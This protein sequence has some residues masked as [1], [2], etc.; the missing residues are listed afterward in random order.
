MNDMAASKRIRSFLV[1]ANNLLRRDRLER[2]LHNELAAHL[3]LHIS[4]NLRS[5]M[6]PAE[7]RRAAGV[8]PMAALRHE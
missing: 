3:D 2:D 6:A 7:A 4:D 5:G 1:R 8:N